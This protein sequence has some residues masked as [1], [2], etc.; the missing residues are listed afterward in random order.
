MKARITYDYKLS[1][2]TKEGKRIMQSPA[3]NITEMIGKI[4]KDYPEAHTFIVLD[5]KKWIGK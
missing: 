1:C 5:K 4:R 2:E 3:H